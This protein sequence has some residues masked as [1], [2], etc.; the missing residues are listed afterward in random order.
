MLEPG[1]GYR[2]RVRCANCDGQEGPVSDSVVRV[3]ELLHINSAPIEYM[4]ECKTCTVAFLLV[5][6][7]LGFSIATQ[8]LQFP[9]KNAA[10]SPLSWNHAPKVLVGTVFQHQEA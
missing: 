9:R 1:R 3:N 6:F 5:S 10:Q 8:N 4:R 7:V 2:F